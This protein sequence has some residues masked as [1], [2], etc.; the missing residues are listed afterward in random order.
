MQW[1]SGSRPG[2]SRSSGTSPRTAARDARKGAYLPRA[3]LERQTAKELWTECNQLTEA[4]AASRTVKSELSI[5]SLFH[6]LERRVKAH[7]LV[8][9]LGYALWATLNHRLRQRG[10]RLTP[11]RALA[12]FV[13]VQTADIIPPTTDVREIRFRRVA[14]RAREP[15]RLLDQLGVAI[16]AHLEWN[17]ERTADSATA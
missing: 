7:V 2:P 3:N 8:A 17:A 5:R 14:T 11:A 13:T 9:F 1:P 10:T 16:P 6:Q 15:R 4:E 12:Q